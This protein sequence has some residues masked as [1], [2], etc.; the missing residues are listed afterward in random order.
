MLEE[1]FMDDLLSC[2]GAS[3]VPPSC[4]G[5]AAAAVSPG[6]ARGNGC[7]LL[8][9]WEPR[10]SSAQSPPGPCHMPWRLT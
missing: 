2:T 10:W 5:G 8:D 9:G 6:A 4:A 7:P 1:A 3:G